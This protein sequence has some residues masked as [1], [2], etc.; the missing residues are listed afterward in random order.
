MP[1][2]TEVEETD[3]SDSRDPLTERIM[4]CAYKVPI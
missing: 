3:Y 4:G 1:D 2:D